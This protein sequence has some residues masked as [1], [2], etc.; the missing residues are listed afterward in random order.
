MG[1]FTLKRLARYIVNRLLGGNISDLQM[2]IEKLSLAMNKSLENAEHN[3]RDLIDLATGVKTICHNKNIKL[4]T[5]YPVAYNSLDHIYPLGTINDN[6]RNYAFYNKCRLLYGEHLRFLDLGCAGG[7]LVFEFALNGHVAIGLE[8]SDISQ[9]TGRV[10]WRTIPGNLFSCDITKD[11]SLV[12]STSN[13]ISHFDVISCWEV[14]EHIPEGGLSTLFRNVRKHL[15]KGGI[16][17]GSISRVVSQNH[18]TIHEEPWW[19]EKFSESGM[20][21]VLGPQSDFSLTE[22]CRGG[23]K[24]INT[25]FDYSRNPHLGFHFVARHKG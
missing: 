10:N 20:K 18:V 11:Y 16:L 8:G 14:L 2:Q 17:I 19:M 23:G 5:D 15:D 12:D 4:V 21:M 25:R 24:D 6:T 13:A 3:Y 7:G 9:N 22:F 1:K